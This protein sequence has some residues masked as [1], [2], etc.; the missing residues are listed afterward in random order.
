MTTPKKPNM[1]PLLL[2]A[3]A[4]AVMMVTALVTTDSTSAVIAVGLLI[5]AF[6]MWLQMRAV[7]K[8]AASQPHDPDPRP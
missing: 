8:L 4:G 1:T 3:A 6:T 7:Q 2:V 5:A